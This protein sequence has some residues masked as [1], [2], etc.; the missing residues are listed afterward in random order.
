VT[1]VP[2]RGRPFGLLRQR[3]FRLLW[4]G[5][6]VSTAG[7]AMATVGVPLLA[8]TVLHASTFAV[9]ALTA[10]AYLPWLVIGLPAGAWVDRLPPRP[11]MI[12]CDVLSALL[13][14]SL[15]LA[16]WTGALSTPLVVAVA[17]LAGAVNVFFA[18]AYQVYL[19]SLVTRDELVEG[20]AKLQ[21]GLSVASI[22][23]RGAVGLAQAV[24]AAPSL[25]FNAGSFLVSA[26]CLLR[27][28]PPGPVPGPTRDPLPV[29]VPDPVPGPAATTP[30]PKPPVRSTV[31]AE[32]AQGVRWVARDPYFRPLTLYA[33]LSNL[34]Y[35]GNLALVVVFLVRVVGLG[36]L[37]VGLATATGG[38]GGLAGALMAG[39]LAR[40]FGSARTLIL[41][42][43]G[44]GLFSLL[45]PLTARGP[46]IA[47][48]VVGSAVVS[49][50]II[51]SNVIAAS[52][53]QEYCP[54]S[55]LGRATASMRLVAF[56]AVPLGALL[57]GA[58]GTALGVRNGL[59]VD[60]ALYA[61]SGSL[62]LTR[63]IRTTRDLPRRPQ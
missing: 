52:F 55:M 61:A 35:S 63:T 7:N 22:T 46:R 45:I 53:R 60:L 39:R 21:A 12:T 56:G 15:P 14:A 51:V 43:L 19:P 29:P 17:L 11:L 23:G 31:R 41:V 28:R 40:T 6:T 27:I 34:A 32:V 5:E 1:A 38:I 16:A 44:S 36:S 57:A 20:N 25:L 24:G 26:A 18:T 8:V 48:Y 42:N 30:K 59:W 2:A 62:L 37:A 4:T 33:A 58:L 47:C 54:P 50:G 13:F 10:A 49:G 3:N 9:A